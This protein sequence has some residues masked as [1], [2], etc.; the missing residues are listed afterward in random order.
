MSQPKDL[1][2]IQQYLQNYAVEITQKAENFIIDQILPPFGVPNLSDKYL[3][4]DRVSERIYGNGDI[5]AGTAYNQIRTKKGTGTAFTLDK[6]GVETDPIDMDIEDDADR[7]MK[8]SERH[9]RE[10]TLQ[11]LIN[12]EKYGLAQVT[13]TSVITNYVTG[14]AANDFPYLDGVNVSILDILAVEAE[15]VR[16]RIGMEPNI[17]VF[18]PRSKSFMEANSEI[19]DLAKNQN[20]QGLIEGTIIPLKLKGMRVVLPKGAY[21]SKSP[22]TTTTSTMADL[23][24]NYMLLAY[25]EP[26]STESYGLGSRFFWAKK[27][28][29]ANIRVT[30]S[31][32]GEVRSHKYRAYYKQVIS[33]ADAGQLLVNIID[34][35]KY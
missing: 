25:V 20:G 19:K 13:S 11:Y 2:H 7:L 29:G 33:N 28:E 26:G 15:K 8:S 12:K 18:G 16:K 21:D 31:E 3:K 14:G 10:L 32:D 23:M 22:I 6:H 35:A 4:F 9:V 27:G 30:D 1:V 34:P 5:M 17:C 24:G